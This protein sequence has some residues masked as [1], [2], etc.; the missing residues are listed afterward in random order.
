M[1]S[2]QICPI[3]YSAV[4]IPFNAV[5]HGMSG[6]VSSAE[7]SVIVLRHNKQSCSNGIRHAMQRNQWNY[8]RELCSQWVGADIDISGEIVG[9]GVLCGSVRYRHRS[10]ASRRKRRKG[11]PG[12]RDITGPP[13]SWGIRGPGPPVWGSLEPETVKCGQE[14]RGTWT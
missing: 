14:S 4:V 13:C 5:C 3:H 9:S 1:A 11:N 12:P 8:R 7:K 10:P 6:I 2:L